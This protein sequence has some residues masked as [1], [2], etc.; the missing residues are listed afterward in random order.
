MHRVPVLKGEAAKSAKR[1]LRTSRIK[2]YSQESKM[3]AEQ[4][5]REYIQDRDMRK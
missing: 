4:A 3:K 5:L 2:P 1:I